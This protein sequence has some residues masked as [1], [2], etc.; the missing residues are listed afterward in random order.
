MGLSAA[1]LVM[2][3]ASGYAIPRE[4][5]KRLLSVS[6][7]QY[8]VLT[9]LARRFAAPDELGADL[10]TPDE[11]DVA[12]FI[13]ERITTMRPK[14][15]EDFL[16]CLGIIEHVLPIRSG[17]ARRFTSL[18]PAEQDHV[19]EQLEASDSGLLRAG[20]QGVKALVFMGYY[21]DP[22]TWKVLGYEGPWVPPRSGS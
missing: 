4:R 16:S 2:F 5:E 14:V 6:A 9:H 19:L 22:R 20:C 21:R 10:P 1:V 18:A 15:R 8:V 3:R 13:D 7:W 17:Y 12:G 11:L